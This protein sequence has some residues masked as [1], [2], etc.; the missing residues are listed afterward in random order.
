MWIYYAYLELKYGGKEHAEVDMIHLIIPEG[1]NAD[2]LE[3][4][5]LVKDSCC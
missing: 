3:N 2:A 5:M 4:Q 1:K